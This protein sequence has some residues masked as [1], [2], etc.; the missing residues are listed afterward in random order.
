MIAQVVLS[1]NRYEEADG[2][3]EKINEILRSSYDHQKDNLEFER[4][5]YRNGST[6]QRFIFHLDECDQ[7]KRTE[8]TLR[9][10]ESLL[11]DYI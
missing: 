4:V 3:E 10:I 9:K 2:I 6:E 1:Y 8:E 7:R 5:D 11:T